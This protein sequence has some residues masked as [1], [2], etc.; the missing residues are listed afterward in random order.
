[1]MKP[2]LLDQVRDRIQALHCS[3]RTEQAYLGRIKRF[4][5]YHNKQHPK[6]MGKRV[7]EAFLIHLAVVRNVSPS[8]KNQGLN[9]ILFLYKQVPGIGV[10]WL[11]DVTRANK[12]ERL[13][14]VLTADQVGIQLHCTC[15]RAVKAAVS[16]RSSRVIT[17]CRPR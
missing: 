12:P 7:V 14:V 13:P 8:T 2:R 3:I 1:M 9:A 11:E 6:Y 5:M 10:V 17:A 15:W 16:Y 4:I